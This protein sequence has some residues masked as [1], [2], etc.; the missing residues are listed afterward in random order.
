MTTIREAIRRIFPPHQPIAAG[1]YQFQSPAD[2]QPPYRLHLRVEPDGTG[3]LIINASTILHLNQTA[4][5]FA[6]YMVQGTIE[7]EVVQAVATRYRVSR[8]QAIQDYQD[9]TNRIQTLITTPDLDP[10]T[11][12][13]FERNA[14]YSQ[15]LSA[16]YRLDCALTYQVDSGPKT[17]APQERVR[18]EMT[19]DEW[20]T[21]FSK[22]W[23]VGIPHIIFT[24]GEPTLRSDLVDLI[25]YC[26]TL[27]QVTG[28]LTDGLRCTDPKYLQEILQAGLDHL[29]LVFQ[30]EEE[31]SWEA[32]RDLL[33]ADLFV[34]VHLT[35]NEGNVEEAPDLLVK[36]SRMGVKALSLS[37]A[38]PQVH[39]A[40]AALREQA[41]RM[42]MELIWDIPVPYSTAHPV[43]LE[44]KGE[45]A[46]PNG[47]GR[48]WLYV[49]PDGDVLPSQGVN[50]VLGNML[51]DPWEK[52]WTA[53]RDFRS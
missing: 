33:A 20:K 26:Q 50:I 45:E 40:L 8:Q 1:T 18:R 30:Q 47:A 6:Y 41:A 31:Q 46:V 38:S 13:D 37:A 43:A 16:P 11:Y 2:V 7:S 53:A 4:T 48:A 5:E 17:S 3:V 39:N 19:T 14:P 15:E 34:T 49:E 42:G 23:D 21:I 35:I 24:G 51:A 10:V 22:A 27:G 44:L 28:L 32:L 36:L 25:T 29:M 52:I 9:L 12:L